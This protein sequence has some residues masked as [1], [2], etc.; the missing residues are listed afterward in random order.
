MVET[1]SHIAAKPK[2]TRPFT[3]VFSNFRGCCVEIVEP[4]GSDDAPRKEM[5]VKNV[6]LVALVSAVACGGSSSSSLKDQS[7]DALPNKSAVAM[8]T[9]GGTATALEAP[10]PSNALT[11]D[12]TTSN[13]F[14]YGLTV[15]VALTFNVPVAVFLDIV[16]N[17]TANEPTSCDATSCTWGPGSAALDPNAYE[18]VV[19]KD[20]DGKSFDWTLS[21][22]AKSKPSSA[23]VPIVTGIATPSGVAHHGSGSFK[24]DFDAAATLDGTHT[25]TGLM[26]VTS[27]SNTGPSQ[28]AVTYT[29]ATDSTSGQREDIAYAYAE[30]AAGGGDLQ[31]AVHNLGGTGVSDVSV[32]SRWKNDGSGRADVQASASGLAVKVSDCWGP[33][34]FLDVYFTSNITVNAPPFAGPT[35]GSPTACSFTD[36]V[37]GSLTIQ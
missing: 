11:A 5:T 31:F 2:G 7:R 15:S 33:A 4:N 10:A 21:G 16:A 19:K 22:Q 18:L 1:L 12:A 34:P 27:Y 26:N 32:H 35:T 23:F 6:L 25:G 14:Y 29:G 30:N 20:S 28:L 24:V 8:N 13:D 3:A 36:T 37:Y 9:P 17:V